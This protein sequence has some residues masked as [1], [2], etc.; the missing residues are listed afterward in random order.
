MK[1][2]VQTMWQTGEIL[3]NRYQLEE[4]LGKNAGRET[5][6][7]QDLNR[8]KNIDANIDIP[9]TPERAIVK[10]LALNP[11]M[12]WD[13]F[14]LFEREAAVLKNLDHPRIPKYRDNF[15]LDKDQGNGLCWFGLVQEYIPGQ[16]LQLLLEQGYHF[17]ETQV[18]AIATQVLEI[19]TYLHQLDPPVLHR[20]IK[21]SNLIWGETEQIYLVDFGAVGDPTFVEGSTFTVVGTAGYAPLEQFWGRAVPASDLY[22][23]GAMLIHLLTGT[24][25]I[26]LP[27]NNLRIQFQDQVSVDAQFIRWLE[28][29]TEP[30]LSGRFSSAPQALEALQTGKSLSPKSATTT[31]VIPKPKNSRVRVTKWP[32]LLTIAIFY[33][34]RKIPSLIY[35]R[36]LITSLFWTLVFITPG[37]I[38]FISFIGVSLL[39]FM[40]LVALLGILFSANVVGIIIGL[41][42][43]PLL[44]ILF[45]TIKWLWNSFLSDFTMINYIQ[46]WLK[47]LNP[48]K[49]IKFSLRKIKKTIN[50]TPTDRKELDWLINTVLQSGLTPE[51]S[52]EARTSFGILIQAEESLASVA[53]QLTPAEHEWLS[54]EIIH[55]IETVE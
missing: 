35:Y 18:R 4:P 45:L 6:L 47:Q 7:V 32:T 48:K 20:D 53:D 52:K 54:S 43:L 31:R 38:C 26:N 1:I 39:F 27:Q 14:K 51:L 10:L 40:T 49:S 36:S 34:N 5:W 28:C 42:I 29:L 21:P 37:M 30:D 3:Q 15:S 11:Q 22:A 8:N 19:L 55:W 23:T 33:Q 2:R 41:I 17:T 50:I 46:E 13:T 25:P 16:S 44:W 12:D 9:D 24:A